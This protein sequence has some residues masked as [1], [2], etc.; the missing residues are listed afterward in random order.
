MGEIRAKRIESIDILRGL[1]MVI[2][3]LDHVRSYFF[4]ESFFGSPTDLETTTVAVFFTRFITH[5]CAPVFVF[6][7]GT[8]DFL[9]GR[10]KSKPK[11]FKFMF[12][13]GIWLIA[14]EI[15]VNTFFWTFDLSY[16]ILIFQV[17]WAI[18]FSMI[19]LS[20]LIYLPQKAIIGIGLLIIFG[21][22]LLDHIVVEG[23][24]MS[25]ILWYLLHQEH[26]LILSPDFFVLFKYPVLPWIGLMALGYCFGALYGREFDPI[27][28]RKW[29]LRLGA[30]AIALFVVLRVTNTYGDMSPWSPQDD[31]ILTFLS[32]INVTKYPPSLL[33][34]LITMGPTFLF[35]YLIDSTKNRVTDF[36]LVF[37][38]VPLFYYFIHVLVIH[39]LALVIMM[40]T[41][42]NWI[43]MILTSD[44]F[45][46]QKLID[47]G[48]ALWV[49]YLIWIVV[50]IILY[51]ISKKYM[52]Y[53]L[54][55]KDK[56]WL[57][58]L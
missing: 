57:S 10:K 23:Q 15:I 40:L 45:A 14:L 41:G 54:N 37:G 53:K 20:L 28:R 19:I 7:A 2:M 52:T 22:N 35:L 3:A 46:N 16:S 4:Y 24:N 33:F 44:V 48:Y 47:Y 51:P 6:L 30:G 8:A 1:V 36:L 55:N 5:F 12:T 32:F 42:E 58:Y 34:V 11:L 21:H 27:I 38:R 17:I 18:G 43:D 50:I 26:L 49:V 25:S 56:W 13:R 31:G 9:Y 39:A 29:L